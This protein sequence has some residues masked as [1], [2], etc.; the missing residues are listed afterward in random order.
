[1]TRTASKALAAGVLTAV[2]AFGALAYRSATVHTVDSGSGAPYAPAFRADRSGPG[3]ML[4]AHDGQAFGSLALD[5][6]LAR[7]ELWSGGRV[8]MGYRAARPVLGW[9]VMLTSF[10]SATAAAWSLLAWTAVGLG[11]TA[12]AAVVLSEVWRR[13]SDWV[14]LLLLLPGAAAQLLF[15]GLCDGLATGLALLGLAWWIDGRDR[16][17]VVALCLAGLTRESALLVPLALLLAAPGR[18][19]LRLTAP[20]AAYAS[21]V[22]IVRLRLGVWPTEAHP[23]GLRLPPG[24]F[25]AVLPSWGWPELLS[26]AIVVT[27]MGVAWRRAPSP[28]VR[29]LVGLSALFGLTLGAMVLQSWL[30]FTRPLLP[31]MVV[32]ACLLARAAGVSEPALE[33]AVYQSTPA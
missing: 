21:W 26:A 12:A 32:G 15:G 13:Q 30:D 5:P 3:A 19:A 16:W 20:F 14:P 31:V 23:G 33:P 1:M 24:N 4:N 18:R 17:A 28:E 8:E 2:L 29:W 6:T 22:G 25:R 9:L 10:G 11:L 27:L 7:P